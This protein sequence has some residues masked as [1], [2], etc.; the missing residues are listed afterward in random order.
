MRRIAFWAT[1]L[2]LCL[3]LGGCGGTTYAPIYGT[4]INEAGAHIDTV[5]GYTKDASV[6]KE[7]MVMQALQNRDNK[8]AE[9]H[10]NSGVKLK[11]IMQEVIP[12]VY[13]Q[14]LSEFQS[15]EQAEFHQPLPMQPSVHPVWDTVKNV[16]STIAK[17]G[18]IGY[19]IGEL[20]NVWQAGLDAATVNY[21]TNNDFSTVTTT[22]TTTTEA[23]VTSTDSSTNSETNTTTNSGG[24]LE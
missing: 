23:P 24:N 5:A 18:L 22:T 4:A 19:G 15:R 6:A 11:F 14:V 12:G 1:I 9:T 10:E 17:Y 2:A 13:V 3:G 21:G 8:I 7:Q 20:S 16:T